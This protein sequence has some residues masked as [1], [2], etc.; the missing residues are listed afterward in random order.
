MA[1]RNRFPVDFVLGVMPARPTSCR[2]G[3]RGNAWA[4]HRQTR[5]ARWT[6]LRGR[7]LRIV[8]FL[9]NLD[10]FGILLVG[11][12]LRALEAETEVPE[13][14][15]VAE[16][17]VLGL[18]FKSFRLPKAKRAL[19]ETLVRTQVPNLVTMDSPVSPCL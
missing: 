8:T 1:G 17:P 13:G 4:P 15:R 7:E 12:D 6:P 5:S 10:R 19:H 14:A 18:S 2:R 3:N 9:P 11:T 16:R